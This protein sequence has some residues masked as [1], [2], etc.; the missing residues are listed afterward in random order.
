MQLHAGRRR[1]QDPNAVKSHV[2][3]SRGEV[4]SYRKERDVMSGG[5]LV[6]QGK[7]ERMSLTLVARRTLVDLG[8]SFTATGLQRR[9]L[10][11]VNS[12]LCDT[13]HAVVANAPSKTCQTSCSPGNCE[14]ICP[15]PP[16]RW[17]FDGGTNRRG[18]I[19]PSADGSAVRTCLVAGGG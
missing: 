8:V 5:L 1:Q 11:I 9:R 12:E 16:R 18:S 3:V 7:L 19:R 2:A 6:T 10:C 14:T 17:Q 15:P 13:Q 4:K